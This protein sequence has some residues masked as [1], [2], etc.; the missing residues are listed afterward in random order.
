MLMEFKNVK[1]FLLFYRF[2]STLLSPIGWGRTK[3]GGPS[4]NI[5]QQAQLPIAAPNTCSARNRPL[6]R[7]V[8][9]VMVCAGGNGRGGCQVNCHKLEYGVKT[10]VSLPL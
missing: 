4:S 9:N 1:W 5:L 6:G 7:V 3:A 8:T 2:I 10:K